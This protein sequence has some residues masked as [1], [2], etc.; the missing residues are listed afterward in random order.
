MILY[1][2][3]GLL[4]AFYTVFYIQLGSAIF[5]FH[6][7]LHASFAAVLF[8]CL[9]HWQFINYHEDWIRHPSVYFNGFSSSLGFLLVYRAN[10]A[11]Q[12]YW[13]ACTRICQM[14]SKLRD[15]ATQVATF[16]SSN[17]DDAGIWKS[18]MLRRLALYNAVALMDL[19]TG[20]DEGYLDVLVTEGVCEQEEFVVI[21]G[22]SNKHALIMLWLND[23]WVV[24]NVRKSYYCSPPVDPF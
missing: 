21:K 13:E 11:Y 24:R 10:L 17:D 3:M 16:I 4:Q 12:R 18:T 5:S 23:A 9:T 7:L 2:S 6:A 14:G 19:R 8:L 15:V 20:E 1:K 22:T